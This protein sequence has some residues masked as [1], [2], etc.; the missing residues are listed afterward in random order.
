MPSVGLDIGKD[1]ELPN[2]CPNA[3][4]RRN[5]RPKICFNQERI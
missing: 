5:R 4:N 2:V 1:L 3:Y